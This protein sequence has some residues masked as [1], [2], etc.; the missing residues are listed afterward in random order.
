L[1]KK[2]K[3]EERERGG[4]LLDFLFTIPRHQQQQQHIAGVGESI[5][6]KENIGRL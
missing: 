3:V 4:G 5:I 1:R 6:T 2:K